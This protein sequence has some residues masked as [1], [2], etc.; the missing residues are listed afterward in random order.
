MG[1]NSVA[2]RLPSVIVPVLSR[3]SVSMSPA[4][5]TA[6]PLLAI[7]LAARARSIPAM[8]I[9]AKSAPI[10]VGIR[11]TEQR[12]QCRD[13][14]RDVEV[15]SHRVERGG[16]DQEDDRK[17]GQDDRERDLVGGLLP[18]RPLDQGDHPVEEA[19]A[20]SGGD[21]DHDPVG[22]HPRSSGHAR[23][24]AAGLADHRR[25]LAGD[26]RLVDRGHALDDL[27]VGR[28]DL[29]DLDDHAVAGL[30]LGRGDLGRLASGLEPKGDRVLTRRP[31]ALRLGL[32]ARLGQG[33]GEVGE[34][35]RQEQQDRQ[36]RLVNDQP[37]GR[38]GRDRLDRDERRQ[39]PARPRPG[40]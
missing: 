6:L 12:D 39:D 8:P 25:A 20:G 23:A 37:R 19:L 28:N 27:A 26:R 4:T 9:A 15:A 18:R 22:E 36:R 16:H 40:T 38:A 10:V 31:Q 13:V 11:Q 30:E 5:S 24:V 32:A 2:L 33:L 7:R 34:E 29:T 21:R 14:E 17:R 1:T 3:S 35:H